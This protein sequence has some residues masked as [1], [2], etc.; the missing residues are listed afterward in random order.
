MAKNGRNLSRNEGEKG[1]FCFRFRLQMRKRNRLIS[2]EIGVLTVD[3]PAS[4]DGSDAS[5]IDGSDASSID[6]LLKDKS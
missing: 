6:V 3:M 5:S 1:C 4:I 2:N